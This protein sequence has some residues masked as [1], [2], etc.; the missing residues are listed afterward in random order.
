LIEV[1]TGCDLV[2]GE[3]LGW[4]RLAGIIGLSELR[5]LRHADDAYIWAGHIDDTPLLLRGARANGGRGGS[6]SSRLL[7]G[8][9]AHKE[10]RWKEY[11]EA[12]GQWS[13]NRWSDVYEA[14]MKRARAANAAVDA[15]HSELGWGVR[16]VTIQI[17]N[18]TRRLDIA[19]VETMRG[20]EYKTGYQT[21]NSENLSE[22]E[23]DRFL[24]QRGWNITWVFEGRVSQPLIDALDEAGIIYEIR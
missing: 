4:W 17:D 2:T 5:H 22:L 23:R 20:I 24:I 18:I 11:Q 15:Y 3:D 12:G 9:Q 14:N 8:S 13:Y 6:K 1:F 19:D 21:A 16:E 10:Q 7:P